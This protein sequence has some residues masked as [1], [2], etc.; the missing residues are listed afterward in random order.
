M[1]GS[2][3]ACH[4]SAAAAQI[5]THIPVHETRA[6]DFHASKIP[7]GKTWPSATIKNWKVTTDWLVG[8]VHKQWKTLWEPEN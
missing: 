2:G 3:E 7:G 6:H 8:I 4:S 1:C 5:V